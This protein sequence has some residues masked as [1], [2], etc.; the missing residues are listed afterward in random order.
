MDENPQREPDTPPEEEV[1]SKRIRFESQ[2][3]E[4]VPNPQTNEPN[5]GQK[6]KICIGCS[7]T[8][9]VLE[10]CPNNVSDPLILTDAQMYHIGQENCNKDT[11]WV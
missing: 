7:E 6:W 9:H 10:S 2:D 11:T 5:C 4:E 3:N 8:G 1:I